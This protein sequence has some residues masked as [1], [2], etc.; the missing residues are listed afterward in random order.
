MLVLNN[1]PFVHA[2]VY[3]QYLNSAL[4]GTA[5]EIYPTSQEI[6]LQTTTM[7]DLH[8]SSSDGKDQLL[9]THMLLAT[10]NMI[11]SVWL[12]LVLLPP[13]HAQH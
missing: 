5:L 13:Y 3:L 6:D 7:I 10:Q 9:R 12:D 4:P 1:T 8:I 11:F 2:C